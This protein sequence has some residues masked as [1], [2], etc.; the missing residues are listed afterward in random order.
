ML[1]LKKLFPNFGVDV[2]D[3][4]LLVELLLDVLDLQYH[5]SDGF[6]PSFD[7]PAHIQCY[8]WS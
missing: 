2:E 7:E 3:L 5:V 4:E 6:Y 1:V 8:F